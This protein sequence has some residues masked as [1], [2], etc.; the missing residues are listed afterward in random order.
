MSSC[1]EREASQHNFNLGSVTV[2]NL[3]TPELIRKLADNGVEDT[4]GIKESTVTN[5]VKRSWSELELDLRGGRGVGTKGKNKQ[6]LVELCR[7]HKIA[8]IKTVDKIMFIM[9]A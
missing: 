4:T 1:R 9:S 3:K 2:I 5:S 8:I 6:E 7:Q